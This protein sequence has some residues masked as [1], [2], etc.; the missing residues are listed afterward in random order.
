M[1]EPTSSPAASSDADALPAAPPP[2][3]PP[4]LV[5]LGELKDLTANGSFFGDT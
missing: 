2:Y 5:F 4:T 1:R 3:A